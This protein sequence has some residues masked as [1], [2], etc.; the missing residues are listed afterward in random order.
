MRVGIVGASGYT[1]AELMRLA[2]SHP[3]MEVVL[4][5]GDTQAGTAVADLYPSLRPVYG[6]LRVRAVHPEAVDGPRR[7]VLRAAPRGQP[8]HRARGQG[9]GEV[10]P[11]PVGRLPAEGPGALPAVVRR[12]AHRARAAGRLRLRAARAVPG[13][14]DRRLRRA[15]C[16]AATRRRPPWPWPRWCGPGM[17]ETTGIVVDAASGRVRC[18]SGPEAHQPLL[19]GRRGLRRLRPAR[20]PAHPG[21]GAGAR[22]PGAV[23]ART[24]PR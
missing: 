3:E 23:H 18:R 13:R 12:R 24:W 17:V 14:A 22:R 1:G 7:R 6:D 15:P 19:H 9:P 20:P 8:G 2:A 4:A 21:D 5:T 16:R 11:G 10:G